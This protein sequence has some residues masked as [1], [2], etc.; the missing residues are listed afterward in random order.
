MDYIAIYKK[1]NSYTAA[2]KSIGI[3]DKTFKKY[4]QIQIEAER[5]KP[6]KISHSVTNFVYFTDAHN[7]PSLP[8]DRFFWLA[9]YVNDINPHYLIDGGDFDDLGSLCGHERNE[10]YR[11][12]FKPSFMNDLEV[13]NEARQIL[14]ENIKAPCAKY[15][16]LGNHEARLWDFENRN[17]EIYGMMQHAYLEIYQRY[18]WG[19]TMYR[20]YKT[21]HDIDFT[22]IPMS[23][24]NKP[25]GG[26]NPC[27]I[28]SRDSIKDV[29]FGHTHGLGLLENHKL[30][31][32]RSVIAFNGGC[33]MPDGYVPDYAKG[34]RKRFWY[35]AHWIQSIDGRLHVRESVTMKELQERYG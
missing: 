17:P 5:K 15:S 25:V 10:T 4:L 18:G 2:G 13:A 16:T 1:Y 35:G 11:G 19:V 8:R 28:I 30:G 12:K 32:S 22:H 34:S 29:C 23:M 20:D 24:M 9:A 21:I 26:Q 33:F 3:S 7:Q 27:N 14:H 6:P 31:G